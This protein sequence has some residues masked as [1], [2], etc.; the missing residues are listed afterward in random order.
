MSNQTFARFRYAEIICSTQIGKKLIYRCNSLKSANQFRRRNN[1]DAILP[2]GKV[3]V[4]EVIHSRTQ[5][6]GWQLF[7]SQGRG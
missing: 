4:I 7:A 1:I 6:I 2:D 5:P 3:S